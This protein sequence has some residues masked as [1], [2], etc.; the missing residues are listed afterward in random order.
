MVLVLVFHMG[1][2]PSPAHSGRSRHV[3]G[4]GAELSGAAPVPIRPQLHLKFFSHAPLRLQA[5][6][7]I[8][9]NVTFL[10]SLLCRYKQY[11]YTLQYFYVN[12]VFTS[13]DKQITNAADPTCNR[14]NK[15][16][17]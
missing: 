17:K 6:F 5:L 2:R 8:K 9:T 14:N 13:C 15:I 16:R 11:K 10:P 7:S 3:S 1:L 12:I 4:T